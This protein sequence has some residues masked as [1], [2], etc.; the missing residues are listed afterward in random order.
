MSILNLLATYIVEVDDAPVQ[1]STLLRTW[2]WPVLPLISLIVGSAIYLRGWSLARRT[3]P[4]ELPP[5]RVVC[6][7][8]GVLS[9]WLAIAS[10]IDAF[11]DYLLAAHMIQHFIL[12]SVAP[13]LFVLSAP[14]VPVLRGL[15]RWIIRKLLQWFFRSRLIQHLLHRLSHPAV[16]WIAMNVTFLGWHVPKAF[17]LTF[18]SEVWHNTEHLCF[19]LTSMAFWFV[20][21]RPWPTHSRWPR[22]TVIPYLLSADIL[23]T[24]LSALLTFSGRVLYPTYEHAPRVSS[25]TAL[26]DQI[27]AG[28]E[29]WVL[30]STVF[31]IPAVVLTF[32]LLSPKFYQH[33]SE[34]L[35][36]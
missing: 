27:V 24:V 30:N 13:L 18:S 1:A 22:W 36:G 14:V 19:F 2:T 26:Q 10:P 3:R 11:D 29:M 33:R 15:P 23:N 21:L 25:L 9:L 16:I 5:W 34:E 6:F 7:I 32:Q 4:S 28:S 35:A 20:V 12:M 31:L 17:E 8:S